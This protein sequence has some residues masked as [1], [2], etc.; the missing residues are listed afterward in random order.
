MQHIPPIDQKVPR[1]T[2]IATFAL[3]CFWGPDARF[4][5][6][7]GVVRTRVGYAGGTTTNPTYR[8]IGNHIETI[9]IDYN[10]TLITFEELLTLF[11][12]FHDPTRPSYKR[13]YT[14][15]LFT[16]DKKQAIL[17][18][19]SLNQHVHDLNKS[20]Y[21]EVIPFEKFHIAEDYHQKYRLRQIPELMQEFNAMYPSA[22]NFMN[23]TAAARVNGYLSGYG[24]KENLKKEIE[25][26][27][28]SSEAK[29]LI[30]TIV[31]LFT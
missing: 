3:G 31:N 1:K 21:T 4:G 9:Q 2:K 6:I 26:F 14:S 27:G 11:W 24:S 29:D 10:P 23:S 20:I 28:L 30:R 5:C 25:L 18:D 13:Q 19:Y 22:I 17:I 16:H 12:K 7:P 8:N 15:A